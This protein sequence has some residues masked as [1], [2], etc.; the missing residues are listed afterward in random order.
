MFG[1]LPSFC[2]QLNYLC[3]YERHLFQVLHE[4]QHGLV[5]GHKA[6]KSAWNDK[7]NIKSVF[8]SMSILLTKYNMNSKT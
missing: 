3:I 1:S 2:V 8:E 4:K 7:Q 6:E 5:N